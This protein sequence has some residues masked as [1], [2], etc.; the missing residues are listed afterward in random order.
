[1][2]SLSFSRTAA[3]FRHWWPWRTG[4]SL[5]AAATRASACVFRKGNRPPAPALAAAGRLASGGGDQVKFWL[6]EEE[7]LI[8]ALCLR[9]GRNLTK[10][11]WV[12]YIGSDIPWQGSCRNRR[13]IWQPP[14][15]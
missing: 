7:K 11:E 4:G 8:A 10:D 13:S 1:M 3:R 5:A 2:A 9:A 12:N 14:E 15:Q 6:V